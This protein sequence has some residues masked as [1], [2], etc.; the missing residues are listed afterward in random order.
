MTPARPHTPKKAVRPAAAAAPAVQP[1][2]STGN[3]NYALLVTGA[4]LVASPFVGMLAPL[5]DW[6]GGMGF[7]AHRQETS[8]LGLGLVH[9]TVLAAAALFLLGAGFRRRFHF[10]PAERKVTR[11]YL[12]YLLPWW[13]TKIP[14]EDIIRV[15][16][17]YRLVR[18]V[19]SARPRPFGRYKGRHE[20]HLILRRNFH[21]VVD[22]GGDR[23]RLS[24]L[25]G[26]IAKITGARLA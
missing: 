20:V 23:D 19:A 10:D 11:D 1:L 9:W 22:H 5:Y 2:T 24:A 14:F 21:I 6:V 8:I 12:L 18:A 16:L 25:A 17:E 15:E 26:D 4:V 7:F 3:P 13:R